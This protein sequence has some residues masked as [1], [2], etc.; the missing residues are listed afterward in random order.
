MNLPILTVYLTN[1]F[2]NK[3]AVYQIIEFFLKNGV[4]DSDKSLLNFAMEVQDTK[5]LH[6]IDIYQKK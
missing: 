2:F 1:I 4:V 5:I 6:L 3:K